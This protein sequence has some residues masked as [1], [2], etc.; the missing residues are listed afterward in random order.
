[1]PKKKSLPPPPPEADDTSSS[2]D[3]RASDPT[4]PHTDDFV[5]VQHETDDDACSVAST[6]HS[7]HH[8][9]VESEHPESAPETNDAP[10]E[11]ATLADDRDLPPTSPLDAFH[12]FMAEDLPK[13]IEEFTRANPCETFGI[14]L[15]LGLLL[16]ILLVTTAAT[17]HALSEALYSAGYNNKNHL[18]LSSNIIDTFRYA[19]STTLADYGAEMT[20]VAHNVFAFPK[21]GCV[22]NSDHLYTHFLRL[23]EEYRTCVVYERYDTAASPHM[24]NKNKTECQEYWDYLTACYKEC[25]IR[26]KHGSVMYPPTASDILPLSGIVRHAFSVETHPGMM[27]VDVHIHLPHQKRPKAAIANAL[28]KFIAKVL[29]IKTILHSYYSRQRNL[30]MVLQQYAVAHAVTES[31]QI[32]CLE[33]LDVLCG[34]YPDACNADDLLGIAFG[35]MPR[36][37]NTTRVIAHV[38]KFYWPYLGDLYPLPTKKIPPYPTNITYGLTRF[39]FTLAGTTG[40]HDF[41]KARLND[42]LIRKDIESTSG[43][44]ARESKHHEILMMGVERCVPQVYEPFLNMT[45]APVKLMMMN[46]SIVVTAAVEHRCVQFLD[47]VVS[48]DWG[49]AVIRDDTI[50]NVISHFLRNHKIMATEV[51]C[52]LLAA[53]SSF[54]ENGT[55]WAWD[56]ERV[57]RALISYDIAPLPCNMKRPSVA[58]PKSVCYSV[59]YIEF[60]CPF[61]LLHKADRDG[62]ARVYGRECVNYLE[63][64]EGLADVVCRKPRQMP[65]QMDRVTMLFAWLEEGYDALPDLRVVFTNVP[66]EVISSVTCEY[67]QSNMD[68]SR[69]NVPSSFGH[70]CK[71]VGIISSRSFSNLLSLYTRDWAR[72]HNIALILATGKSV[73]KAVTFLR[74]NKPLLPIRERALY[75]LIISADGHVY[76]ELKSYVYDATR[77]PHIQKMFPIAKFPQAP[78]QVLDSLDHVPLQ[79]VDIVTCHGVNEKLCLFI[80]SV[81]NVPLK[82]GAQKDLRL[83]FTDRWKWI[84]YIADIADIADK[85][86]A[87][88]GKECDRLDNVEYTQCVTDGRCTL[89]SIFK[90]NQGSFENVLNWIVFIMEYH[91]V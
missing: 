72:I 84:T 25:D 22:L 24:G 12:T 51:V 7:S 10:S 45:P 13:T 8:S 74:S 26:Q 29:N 34:F 15:G 91:R 59:V 20:S 17:S 21:A 78:V 49:R 60:D 75:D 41:L 4:L 5:D 50:S 89:R 36:N 1:M 47:A 2:S 6:V 86:D 71:V 80:H 63:D 81:G 55:A 35:L 30:S 79:P 31:V 70:H 14:V 32:Q 16:V 67:I 62:V 69:H 23:A 53:H 56:D 33:C 87:K 39:S 65:A 61:H 48:R 38:A 58:V 46:S 43:V 11:P 28:R 44:Q 37:K 9:D 3:D 54:P 68:E 82:D 85:A 77:Y 40:V 90:C 83:L 19:N 57:T 42:R 88:E 52:T 76:E 27:G 18:V 73:I 66:S 64:D